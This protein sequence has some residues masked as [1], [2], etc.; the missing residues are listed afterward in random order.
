MK[1]L[2]AP[3]VC[4]HDI[5][6]ISI[7]FI[8]TKA[9]TPMAYLGHWGLLATIIT[10]KFMLDC[11]PFLLEAIWANGTSSHAFQAHLQ[12]AC[13]FFSFG[14]VGLHHAFQAIFK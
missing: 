3:L 6:P 12:L 11:Q 13:Y 4:W 2:E 10:S 5:F 14:N 8:S 1:C 9:I 7:S